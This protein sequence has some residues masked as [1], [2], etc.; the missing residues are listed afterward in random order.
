MGIK[1]MA[2]IEP[3]QKRAASGLRSGD[4][5]ADGGKG[6]EIIGQLIGLK[7]MADHKQDDHTTKARDKIGRQKP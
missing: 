3:D 4:D 2:L 1:L 5:K 7:M 6:G